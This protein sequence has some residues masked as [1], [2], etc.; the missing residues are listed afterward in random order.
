MQRADSLRGFHATA[1]TDAELV[2]EIEVG[3]LG[4]WDGVPLA[5]CYTRYHR[6]I[7]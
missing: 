4:A 2:K 7:I 1:A 3:L 6:W 5:V